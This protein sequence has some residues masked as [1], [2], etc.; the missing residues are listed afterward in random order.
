MSTQNHWLIIY[1]IRDAKRLVKVEKLMECYG[2]RVQKSVFESEA[3]ETAVGHLKASL[4]HVTAE[5]DFI[6]F[7]PVCEKCWQ[8]REVYGLSGAENPMSGS[9]MVL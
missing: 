3:D 4:E 2:W 7:C 9:F 5:E 1:D 6:L 8:K